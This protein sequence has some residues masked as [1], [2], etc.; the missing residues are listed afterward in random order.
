VLVT[1]HS[2]T[3]SL[4]DFGQVG[5][6]KVGGINFT[7]TAEVLGRDG[8]GFIVSKSNVKPAGK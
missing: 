1:A 5:V 6:T 3:A 7:G 4:A 8:F 2:P